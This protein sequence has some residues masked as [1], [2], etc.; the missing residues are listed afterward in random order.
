MV[1]ILGHLRSYR[2]VAFSP[3]QEVGWFTRQPLAEQFTDANCSM[4][5]RGWAG[6]GHQCSAVPLQR[7]GQWDGGGGVGGAVGKRLGA[8]HATPGRTAK[9]IA[10]PT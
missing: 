2:C 7:E 4:G 1:P 8:E 6:G 5:V 3:D 10:R 9:K